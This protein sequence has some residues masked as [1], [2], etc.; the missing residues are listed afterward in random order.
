MRKGFSEV[1]N[2]DE[3]AIELTVRPNNQLATVSMYVNGGFKAYTLTHMSKQT[4]A[5]FAAI[6][7][8]AKKALGIE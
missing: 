6:V 8:K 5:E 1:V 2:V 7:D 3:G 4:F